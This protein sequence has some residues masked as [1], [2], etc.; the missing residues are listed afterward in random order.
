MGAK[1]Q[2]FALSFGVLML[3]GCATGRN[4][5]VTEVAPGVFAGRKPSSDADFQVLR[6]NGIRTIVNLQT[7]TWDIAPERK[8]AAENGIAFRNVPVVASPFG[9][10]EQRVQQLFHILST[11]ALQPVYVHCLLGRDRTGV[12]MA[13]YRVYY[14]NADPQVAWAEMLRRGGFKSRWALVGFSVYYWR[15]CQ[16]PGWVVNARLAENGDPRLARSSL[17]TEGANDIVSK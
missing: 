7:M 12:L 8:R 11:P 5:L 6:T 17:R 1:S 14:E 10:R 3:S 13:L 16:K 15:H 9:P 4:L 2:L